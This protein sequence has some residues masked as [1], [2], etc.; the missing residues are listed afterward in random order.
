MDI[1]NSPNFIDVNA[2]TNETLKN[3]NKH[4]NFFIQTRTQNYV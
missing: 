2:S 3:K 1:E 4:Q